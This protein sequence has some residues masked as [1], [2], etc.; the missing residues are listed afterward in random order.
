MRRRGPR[1]QEVLGSETRWGMGMALFLSTIV[2]K[3]D[4]KGRVSVPAAFR[5]ALADQGFNGVVVFPSI[6][7]SCIEGWGMTRMEELAAGIPGAR[8]AMVEDCGHY[9]PVEHPQAVTA[10]MRQ[11]LLYP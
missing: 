8:L 9:A 4:R 3:V 6:S 11:W 10:L 2:N 7:L 1:D 5:V